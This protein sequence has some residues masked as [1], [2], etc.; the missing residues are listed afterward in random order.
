[1]TRNNRKKNTVSR[2]YR[3]LGSS[4]KPTTKPAHTALSNVNTRFDS[5]KKSYIVKP[6][7]PAKPDENRWTLKSMYGHPL[8]NQSVCEIERRQRRRAYFGFKSSVPRNKQNT[9]G[10]GTRFNK[11]EGC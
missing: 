9:G 8:L 1:M 7:T 11:S 3:R 2:P 6:S 4:R 5:L 10:V